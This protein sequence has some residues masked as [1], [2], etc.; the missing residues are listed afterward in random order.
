MINLYGFGPQLL[1]GVMTTLQLAA[2]SL[3]FGV[4]I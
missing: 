2:V 3:I 1:E 4:I